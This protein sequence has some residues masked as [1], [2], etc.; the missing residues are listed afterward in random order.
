MTPE[1]QD[2]YAFVHAMLITGDCDRFSSDPLS[3]PNIVIKV[4][5]TLRRIR[6]DVRRIRADRPHGCVIRFFCSANSSGS[7]MFRPNKI[8]TEAGFCV[9]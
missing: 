9:L 4:D 1:Q 2:V 7:F 5:Q 3:S 6:R 8:P